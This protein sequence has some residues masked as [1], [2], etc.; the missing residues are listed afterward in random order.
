M[1]FCVIIP[2]YN[3]PGTLRDV[4]ERTL[5]QCSD[6]I[7]VDDGSSVPAASLLQGVPVEVIPH[8]RNLGKGAALRTGFE[9]ARREGYTH[10]VTIDA[11]SQHFP[12]DI[13][14]LC[15]LSLE[16]PEAFIIG[17]RSLAADNMPRG[18]TFA[19]RF[20]NFW[21]RLQTGG[22]LPDTQS[23]FRVYPLHRIYGLRHITARYEAELELLVYAAWHG[24]ELIPA[25]IRVCYPE[26]R[27]SHFRPFADFMRISALNTALCFGALFYGLPLAAYRKMK[28]NG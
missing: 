28:K 13:P 2:T 18:N 12:E 14:V 4:V 9:R 26:D 22:S 15:S 1:E 3:N 19:N 10:C 21:F 20:S 7:V 5:E 16:H 17:S 25:D 11:D 8:S 24:V 23:G 6:V 27:V